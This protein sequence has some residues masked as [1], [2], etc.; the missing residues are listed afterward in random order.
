M[1]QIKKR[2][3]KNA[4]AKRSPRRADRVDADRVDEGERPETD[5]RKPPVTGRGPAPDQEKGRPRNTGRYG[6]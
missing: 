4:P 2:A 1:A 3:G 6:A 5:P